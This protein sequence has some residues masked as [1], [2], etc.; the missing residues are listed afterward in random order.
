MQFFRGSL[1]DVGVLGPYDTSARLSTEGPYLWID[2]KV[3]LFWYRVMSGQDLDKNDMI[4]NPSVG[5]L[6]QEIR[7][8]AQPGRDLEFVI[9]SSACAA[10]LITVSRFP[11]G[12]AAL[13]RWQDNTVTTTMPDVNCWTQKASTLSNKWARASTIMDSGVE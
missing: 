2:A 1:Q 9:K 8:A 7:S 13:A 11:L 6:I 4:S 10:D 3:Q 12:E 5:L